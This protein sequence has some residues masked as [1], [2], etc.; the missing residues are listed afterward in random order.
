MQGLLGRAGEEG[1][2]GAAYAEPMTT[3][4][5]AALDAG[6]RRTLD[7]LVELIRDEF[8]E[9][10]EA[11]WLYGSRARGERHEESDVD[12]MVVVD[13]RSEADS[14]RAHRLARQ[15]TEAEETWSTLLSVRVR[16]RGWIEGRRQ[17]GSFFLQ[18]VDRD[19]VVLYGSR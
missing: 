15:A 4:A 8:G 7:R 16:D 13:E 17:I 1:T 12:V 14:R 18:E 10:L 11:V 19:R 2:G 3:L 5:S 6:E 9:R